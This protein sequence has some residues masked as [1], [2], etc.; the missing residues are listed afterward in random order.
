MVKIEID[1]AVLDAILQFKPTLKVCADVIGTSTDTIEKRIKEEHGCTFSEYRDKKMGKVK[2]KLQQKAIEMA[3]S[4]N[5]TMMIFS[6]KNLCG[7][8]DK[9]E[10]QPNGSDKPFTFQIVRTDDNKD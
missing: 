6:L 7:W 5:A 8:A 2:I 1:W 9:I 4:G 10:H 3:L